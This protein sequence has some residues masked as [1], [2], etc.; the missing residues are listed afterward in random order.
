[1]PLAFHLTV[2]VSALALLL[3]IVFALRVGQ[4]RVRLGVMAPETS[5]PDEF[6]RVYR[7]HQ[8]TIEQLVLFLPSLWLFYMVFHTIWGAVVGVIWILARLLYSSAYRKDPARRAPGMLV[9]IVSSL[10]LLLCALLGSL[11][12]SL[13]L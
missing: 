6:N 4:A 7:V 1:M 9:T 13:G 2:I 5:G 12:A 8:N 11:I 10:A 3:N